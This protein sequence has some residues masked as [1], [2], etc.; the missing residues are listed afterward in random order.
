MNTLF[1]IKLSKG[2]IHIV[3]DIRT[4]MNFLLTPVKRGK[5]DKLQPAREGASTLETATK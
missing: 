5:K 1:D 3:A 2:K 4:L